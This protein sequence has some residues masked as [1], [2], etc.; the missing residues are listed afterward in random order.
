MSIPLNGE[1]TEALPPIAM[2]IVNRIMWI[3]GCNDQYKLTR[4]EKKIKK[5]P[6]LYTWVDSDSSE[7]PTGALIPL[8][9]QSKTTADDNMT[10][11]TKNVLDAKIENLM[12]TLLDNNL[13]VDKRE[14]LQELLGN[15]RFLR[16]IYEEGEYLKLGSLTDAQLAQIKH[17][18]ITNVTEEAKLKEYLCIF[19]KDLPI[20]YSKDDKYIDDSYS[21]S[22]LVDNFDADK[23]INQE[24][25][26][27]LDDD[28]TEYIIADQPNRIKRQ[29]QPIDVVDCE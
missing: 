7:E 22:G 8:L 2:E 14:K 27:S 19:N 18:Q 13:S 23:F 6:K 9:Y 3:M 15:L 25:E 21:T 10:M 29:S 28:V 17:M 1:T 24:Y 26:E 4:V 5:K 16:T 20:A 12:R 11:D